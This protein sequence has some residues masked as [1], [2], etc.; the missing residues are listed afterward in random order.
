MWSPKMLQGLG[1]PVLLL[2]MLSMIAL[3]LPPLVLDLL[4]TFNIALAMVVV[5]ASVYSARPLDFSVFPTVLL[6]ATL[7]RLALNI[8]S[9]RVVL[10]EGHSGG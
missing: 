4:F 8:A 10:L 7:L 1:A 5:L 9:T 6:M 2:A 3:P